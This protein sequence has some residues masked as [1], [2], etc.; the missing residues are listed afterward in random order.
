MTAAGPHGREQVSR[1]AEFSTPGGARHERLPNVPTRLERPAQEAVEASMVAVQERVA[2]AVKT[3]PRNLRWDGDQ[4][5]LEETWISFAEWVGIRLG[6]QAAC[7]LTG[8]GT[9]LV[10]HMIEP[11]EY[12]AWSQE[13]YLVFIGLIDSTTEAGKAAKQ[14]MRTNNEINCSIYNAVL[15]LRKRGE[16]G[17]GHTSEA[18]DTT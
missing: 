3:L 9:E 14:S 10:E 18:T 7:A 8:D 6:D 12:K 15:H 16:V 5:T 11:H 1:I 13:L 4:D 2:K 17:H